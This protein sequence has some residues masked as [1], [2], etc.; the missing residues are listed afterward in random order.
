MFSI[1]IYLVLSI[2]IAWLN[3]SGTALPEREA[4]CFVVPPRVSLGLLTHFSLDVSL[5]SAQLLF[6]CLSTDV[7]FLKTP[8]PSASP[9]RLGWGAKLEASSIEFYVC[10]GLF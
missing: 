5:T 2:L 7:L 3:T 1:V 8:L 6:Y 4:H 9:L 10:D